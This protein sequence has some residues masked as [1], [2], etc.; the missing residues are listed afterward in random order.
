MSKNINDVD[1]ENIDLSEFNSQI[2]IIHQEIE[3]IKQDKRLMRKLEK[4]KI[5]DNKEVYDIVQNNIDYDSNFKPIK[6]I[7]TSYKGN[8]QD[9][10]VDISSQ[11]IPIKGLQ[12][13]C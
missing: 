1:F 5:E 3:K 9:N 8:N 12:P 11:V 7:K 4:I 6:S 13:F 2:E 10:N